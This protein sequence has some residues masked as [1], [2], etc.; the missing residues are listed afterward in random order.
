M[1]KGKNALM[2]EELK[3]KIRKYREHMCVLRSKGEDK[4]RLADNWMYGA[5]FFLFL[6]GYITGAEE[7]EL[8]EEYERSYE[9]NAGK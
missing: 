1:K 7:D 6:S 9:K 3:Q 4:K 5:L 8:Y 2:K